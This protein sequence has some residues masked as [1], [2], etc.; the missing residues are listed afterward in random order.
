M[1]LCKWFVVQ[2]KYGQT[3]LAPLFSLRRPDRNG[4]PRKIR[5]DGI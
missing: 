2:P 1:G 5:Q 4:M 3:V